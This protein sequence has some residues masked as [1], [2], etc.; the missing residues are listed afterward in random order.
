VLK[1]QFLEALFEKE[2]SHHYLG[3]Q[4]EHTYQFYLARGLKVYFCNFATV[5]GYTHKILGYLIGINNGMDYL[6][7][8]VENWQDRL[9]KFQH[10]KFVLFETQV[11]L[12]VIQVHE[13]GILEFRLAS[14][15]SDELR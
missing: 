11:I 6:W 3:V 9:L 2:S 7:Q 15:L 4:F 8:E 12:E 5:V 13:D 14:E 1:T 10:E